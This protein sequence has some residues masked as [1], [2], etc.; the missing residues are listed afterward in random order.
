MSSRTIS[1]ITSKVPSPMY[2]S[3]SRQVA[4]KSEQT[5][6]EAA[7]WLRQDGVEIPAQLLDGLEDR[8]RAGVAELLLREPAG[9]HADGVEAGLAG[10]LDVPRRIADHQAVVGAGLLE[11]G[12]NEVGLRLRRLDVV[13]GRPAVG[14]LP[15]VEQ[16][17]VAVELILR[18]RAREHDREAALLQVGD[19]LTRAFERLDLADQLGVRLAP[20]LADLVA[21]RL[22]DLLAGERGHQL[23][24]AHA[25]VPVDPPEREDGPAPA[26]RSIPGERVLVVRV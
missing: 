22:F 25:D 6:F 9:D 15:R 1:T 10:G 19:Q 20:E 11:R 17:Q 8:R 14:Q 5:T 16:L 18:R 24:A 21:A 26:E 4:D 23:V 12:A 7:S 2:M 3:T 13:V